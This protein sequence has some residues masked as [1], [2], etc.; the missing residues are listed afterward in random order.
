MRASVAEGRFDLRKMSLTSGPDTNPSISLSL[1]VKSS[2]YLALSAGE[3]THCKH[4]NNSVDYSFQSL[5]CFYIE[6]N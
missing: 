5:T 4:T 2:S 1:L 3:T 6:T